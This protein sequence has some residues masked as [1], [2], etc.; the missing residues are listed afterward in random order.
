MV[1]M[2]AK[3][4][5]KCATKTCCS[6]QLVREKDK[7]VM[8]RCNLCATPGELFTSRNSTLVPPLCPQG[9]E[10]AEKLKKQYNKANQVTLGGHL[11]IDR[12]LVA[13]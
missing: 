9:H 1:E 5:S 11:C 3:K 2:T 13:P 10:V 6:F 4:D 8:V 7:K 12:A